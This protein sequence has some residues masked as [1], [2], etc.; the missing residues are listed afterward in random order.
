MVLR[1][2]RPTKHPKTGIY[3]LRKRVPADL[4]AKLGHEVVTKSL[5]TRN[6]EEA[7]RKHALVLAELEERWARLREASSDTLSDE[8]AAR[9]AVEVEH[10][11]FER[12]RKNPSHQVLWHPEIYDGLWSRY[13]LAETEGEDG[14]PGIADSVPG[15]IPVENA[16]WRSM[17]GFCIDEA[18]GLLLSNG[19]DDDPWS[20]HKLARAVGAAMQRASLRLQALEQGYAT[21]SVPR[22]GMT[23]LVPA[24]TREE[25][26]GPSGIMQLFEDWWREAAATGRKPSTHES[27]LHTFRKFVEFLSHDDL[28]RVSKADIIAFKDYRLSTPSTRTG[29]AP[30]PKTVKESDLSALKA[31]FGWGVN[32][33]R[34]TDNPA[35]NV[36][37]K[38]PKPARLRPKGFTDDEATALLTKALH[39]T[40]TNESL[41]TAA[42]KRWVP[43]LC[44]FTG[45]RVGEMGQ[46]RRE[47]VF[48]SGDTWAIRI[49]PDAGTV[50]T[51]QMREVPLHQQLLEMEFLAFV[52]MSSAG[53]LFLNV[54][55]GTSVLGVL[56]GL[57]NRLAEFGREVVADPNIAPNHGWRHRFKT[58][59][60]EAGIPPRIL[61]AIQGQA[62]RSVADTY[63]EVTLKAMADAIA[64]LPTIPVN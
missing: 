60:M 20:L 63:G 32:N 43:W 56:Q 29:R 45:A 21:P 15:I 28:Y 1:V 7:K 57:K 24:L 34:L 3:W 61:D 30:S 38:L 10:E 35:A 52:E 47:D 48:R 41:K 31:V 33:G 19:F 46:L 39:Y 27:Y 36:T 62:P 22:S 11:W 64:R 6:P 16:F 50:K 23:R 13:P 59:G 42:A 58:V 12:H 49:S 5:E 14:V 55:P 4:R 18:K 9:I 25:Y 53:H 8:S 37:I 17:R 26:T 2:S 40:S 51:N 44:A 54:P